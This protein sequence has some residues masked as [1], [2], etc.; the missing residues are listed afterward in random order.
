MRANQR[1]ING[2]VSMILKV[3]RVGKDC[4]HESRW[5]ESM[6]SNSM[7]SCPL[8]LMYK[9]HKNWTSSRGTPPPTCPVM[10]GNSGMN[11]HLSELL[12][13]LLEPL[14]NSMM[15]K[16]SEV[17]SDKHLKNKIDKLNVINK[18]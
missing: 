10:G 16:S 18:E 1:L 4:K 2:A 17:I 5:R 8:W 12:S 3:F 14:A 11:T 6:I 7:E 13:W 9:D 15:N